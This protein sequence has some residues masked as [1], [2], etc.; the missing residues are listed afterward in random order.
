ADACKHLQIVG[1]TGVGKTVLAGNL[2][3]QA[4]EDDAGVIVMERKGDLF[5]MALDAVPENRLDDVIV[6]VVGDT[7]PAGFNLLRE[8]NP[9]IAVEE[10]CQLFEYLYPDMRRGIWARAALH[11][12]LSTLITRPGM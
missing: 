1:P 5:H 11:R 7:R 4:I 12:G 6:M 8:G 3:R 2:V 10:L 9:R